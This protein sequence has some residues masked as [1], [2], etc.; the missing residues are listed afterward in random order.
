MSRSLDSTRAPYA[1][2]AAT[3]VAL[4][5]V[6]LSG[7]T[8][9]ASPASVAPDIPLAP[10]IASG[11]FLV[12]L[13]E[14]SGEEAAPI[15]GRVWQKSI[16]DCDR[17]IG[18]SYCHNDPVNKYDVLGL[19]TQ[20]NRKTGALEIVSFLNGIYGANSGLVQ[21]KGIDYDPLSFVAG[22]QAGTINATISASDLDAIRRHGLI[23]EGDRNDELSEERKKAETAARWASI[24]RNH[25][26]LAKTGLVLGTAGAGAVVDNPMELDRMSS[27]FTATTTDVVFADKGLSKIWKGGKI[28]LAAKSAGSLRKGRAIVGLSDEINALTLLPAVGYGLEAASFRLGTQELAL[29]DDLAPI[30]GVRSGVGTTLRGQLDEIRRIAPDAQI[31]YRGSLARGTKGAHKGNAPFDAGDFDVDAFIVSDTLAGQFQKSAWFRSGDAVSGL[32]DVQKALKASLS[33][34]FPG[35]RDEFTFRI[36]TE[37]EFLKK[38]ATDAHTLIK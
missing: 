20:R 14:A 24:R 6:C 33:K 22:V 8:Q 2:L 3:F 1:V 7:F 19:Y 12:N 32:S 37:A 26:P 13:S 15:P 30:S 18:S 34:Q 35:M 21:H 28:V 36:F 29:L 27:I 25:N 9:A 23:L 16:P 5:L 11:N 31:G 10:E 4:L 17:V 38:V